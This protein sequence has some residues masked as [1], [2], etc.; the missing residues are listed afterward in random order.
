MS[1]R[2]SAHELAVEPFPGDPS[3]AEALDD[4]LVA[5]LHRRSA[6]FRERRLF[7]FLTDGETDEV[8]CTFGELEQRAIAVAAGLANVS[9]P[10]D[11]ALLL[12]APGIDYIVAFFGCLLAGVVAVPAYPPDPTR[13]ARTLP[14]LRAIARD[15]GSRVV[16]TSRQ[17]RD[18]A[19][20]FLPDAPE[21]AEARWLA[22]DEQRPEDAESWVAPDVTPE[23]V[24]FLQYT[25]GL[26]RRSE[27]RDPD[28]PQ[29][30]SQ[31]AHDSLR[32]E[33]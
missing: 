17:I 12:F 27:G 26:H 7:T 15:S 8:H 19:P 21:L 31:P 22:V 6:A 5:L 13:L 24:A 30:P 10:G 33:H 3:P 16:L 32:H 9:A 1:T 14:K 29:H 28:P 18:A 25:S 4:T 11:R 23:T 2:D 20:M